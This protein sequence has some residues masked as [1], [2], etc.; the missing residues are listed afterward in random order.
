MSATSVVSVPSVECIRGKGLLRLSGQWC[1]CW[2]H[3]ALQHHQLL[4]LSCTSDI[5][6]RSWSWIYSCYIKSTS[7]T[8]S[9]SYQHCRFSFGHSTESCL[10]SSTTV[11]TVC[12]YSLTLV[13]LG[14]RLDVYVCSL[15]A[16]GCTATTDYVWSEQ[17]DQIHQSWF[18]HRPGTEY[19]NAHYLFQFCCNVI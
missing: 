10:T 16:G 13:Y 9:L 12:L 5:V 15:T 7:F 18:T 2:L 17:P 1:V 6:K 14:K 8:L 3:T 4:P 11:P 19:F